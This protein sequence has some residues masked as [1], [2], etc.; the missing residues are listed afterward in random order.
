[1]TPEWL[2]QLT[3]F[4]AGI[5][6]TGAFWY[7]L[8]QRNYHGTLWAGYFTAVFM[9]LAVA[10][11]IRNDL[12]RKDARPATA[13]RFDP[14]AETKTLPQP[15]SSRT[16]KETRPTEIGEPSGEQ[17]WPNQ[18]IINSPGAI[19]A[20]RD[21]I[22]SADP[23]LVRSI[24][25]RVAVETT[26]TPLVPD[27][28]TFDWGL[29][30]VIALFTKEKQRFRFVSDARVFDQQ[31]TDTRRRVRFVY[32][33]EDPGQVLGRPI[34]LLET[35]DVLAVNYVEIFQTEKFDT[36]LGGTAFECGIVVNGLPVA[37]IR[38]DVQPTGLLNRQ[39]ANLNVADT[40]GKI[41]AAYKAII[42]AKVP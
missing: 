37:Q 28:E 30:S 25:L 17:Q 36:S 20:G 40:F 21:V 11:L 16:G 42:G 12:I 35:F 38:A 4:A 13:G 41:P 9:L 24:E 26:T 10:F 31:V 15:Q 2:V 7:F 39:Q 14:S 6:A 5:S 34:A 19:Q 32:T 8:G 23:Q 22:I 1:M 33:P 29:G 18:S 27:A 3:W